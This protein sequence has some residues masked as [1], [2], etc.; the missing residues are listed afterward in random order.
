MLMS[1]LLKESHVMWPLL[2]TPMQRLK[3]GNMP[4]MTLW[5]DNLHLQIRR[6]FAA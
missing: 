4:S 2:D 1:S 6:T 3:V 5:R